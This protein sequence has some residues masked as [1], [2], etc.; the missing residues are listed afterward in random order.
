MWWQGEGKKTMSVL[1]FVVWAFE[2]PFLFYFLKGF[3]YLFL[4]SG[5]GREKESERNINVWLPLTYPLMGIWTP[6]KHVPWL[7]I[8]P[9]TLCFTGLCS[10]HWAT[11]A[12]TLFYFSLNLLGWHWLIILYRLQV[13]IFKICLLIMLLQLSH[14]RPFTQLHPVHHLPPTFP[15]L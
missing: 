9:A 2:I 10:I 14:F 13:Y 4:E 5:D 8:E 3:I 7:G 12:R 6:N 1:L 15:P 11:P